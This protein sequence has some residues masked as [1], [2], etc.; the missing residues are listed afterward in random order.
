M[1][2]D[3]N[4]QERVY[5]LTRHAGQ[6]RETQTNHGAQARLDQSRVVR[7]YIADAARPPLKEAWRR[8]STP[9]RSVPLERDVRCRR[10]APERRGARGGTPWREVAGAV[11]VGGVAVDG[12]GVVA[13]DRGAEEL[14]EV[15]V[16]VGSVVAG[17]AG[18]DGAD[19]EGRVDGADEVDEGGRAD[20]AEGGE[21]EGEEVDVEVLEAGGVLG[22][23]VRGGCVGDGGGE[24]SGEERA[25]VGGVEGEGAG[26]G[27]VGEAS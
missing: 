21:H 11:L 10:G 23:L 27:G 17:G 15:G 13:G 19:G 12:V 3:I 14:L 22:R 25:G 24:V 4:A 20:A 18:M 7:V 16:R 2:T 6:T 1:E 5:F 9:Y 26:A 8:T